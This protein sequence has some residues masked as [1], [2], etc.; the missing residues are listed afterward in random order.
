MLCHFNN[1]PVVIMPTNVLKDVGGGGGGGK[2]QC[3]S[4][5]FTHTDKLQIVLCLIIVIIGLTSYI[6]IWLTRL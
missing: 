5:T 4:E 1:V 2:S 6:L 3:E